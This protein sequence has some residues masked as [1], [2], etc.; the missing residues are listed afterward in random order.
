MLA[1]SRIGVFLFVGKT[2]V[3]GIELNLS[4]PV[5]IKAA[6]S[7]VAYDMMKTYTGN[8]TGQTPG[9]L[10]EPYFWWEAG[11]MFGSMI[12]YYYYTGDDTYNDVVSQALLSQIGPNADYMPPAQSNDEG[13]DDQGFW[14]MA[15]MSAAEQNFPNPPSD[16]PQWLALAQAVFNSQAM[17]WDTTTCN[18]GLRWQIFTFNNGYTYKNS[19]SNG[20]FFNL[21]ARLAQYTGN[22]TYADWAVKT[23]DWVNSVDFMDSEY[24]IFD[25]AGDTANCTQPNKIRWTYNAGVYL[26]GAATMYS[27]TNRS[28]VWSER[29]EGLLNATDFFFSPNQ[30]NVMYETA[31]EPYGTCDIDQLSFKA[32]LSRWM[33]AST[34]VAPFIYD[35]V[36]LKLQASAT[37]AAQQCSGGPTGTTCGQKWTDGTVWDGTSGVGQQMSALEVIQ[38]NLVKNSTPPITAATGGTSKG[39]PAAGSSGTVVSTGAIITQ[40]TLAEKISAGFITAFACIMVGGGVVWIVA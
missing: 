9:L 3:T 24:E 38:S 40:I 14:G 32:Y 30:T 12:D 31:C 5:S 8:Q 15:A 26:L 4:D 35:A 7:T 39:N 25:G 21:A 28:S 13:N 23:W 1:W 34:Q 36:M 17:R 19:I 6:A 2:L 16:Q 33:A 20:V 22:Q 10:P 18:G 27:Y 11:A 37:A 29:V